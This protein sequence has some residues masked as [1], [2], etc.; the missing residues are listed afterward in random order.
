VTI[1]AALFAAAAALTAPTSARAGCSPED[2]LNGLE[3]ALGSLTSSA[4]AA[5]CADGA[6]C[7][8][9]GAVT[10]A[11]AGVSAD[12]SQGTV[13][14]FCSAVQNALNNVTTGGDDANSVLNFL[15]QYA[16]GVSSAIQQQLAGAL[17]AVASPLN[18][19]ECGCAIEQGVGQ[20]TSAIGSCIQEALCSLDALIGSPCTC[21]PPPPVQASC[22]QS[23]TACGGY[24]DN[25]PAC[26]GNGTILQNTQPGYEPVRTVTGAGG[27]MVSTG[28]DSSDGAGHCSPVVFCFCPQPMVPTWT[29]D[30][31]ADSSGN[32][33]IFSCNCPSGTHAGG[34]AG[35]LSTC[36][37][38]NTNQPPQY[39][40][41]FGVCAPPGCPKGQE[42]IGGKCVTPCSDPS[43]GMTADGS[44]CDPKQVTS[45]G[46]CCPAGTTPDP[47]SG[48]CVP[49]QKIE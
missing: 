6:G 16:P 23:N 29:P 7:A 40:S 18:V 15:N 38:D 19:A 34:T 49:P 32:T 4:C 8:A 21:T 42:K 46:M 2:L 20:L 39:G 10:V 31:S 45:C 48:T 1:S 5:A 9:A 12:S 28:G 17:S 27:T 41:L 26:Q 30:L 22:A 36:L 44:C 14:Q 24:F 33:L 43:M 37:C 47:A 11:L 25:D 3:N 35:G 13:D